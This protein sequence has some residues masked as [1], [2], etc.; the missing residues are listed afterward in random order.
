MHIHTTAHHG[1]PC[2]KALEHDPYNVKALYR[3]AH[4]HYHTRTSLGLE[5]AVKDLQAAQKL[6]PGNVQVCESAWIESEHAVL[7]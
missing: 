2:S 7:G 6:E 5:R 1:L 3:R 4:G